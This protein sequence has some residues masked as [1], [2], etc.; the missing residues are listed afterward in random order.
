MLTIALTSCNNDPF[1]AGWVRLAVTL[2][3]AKVERV[4][5]ETLFGRPR[6]FGS[7][8]DYEAIVVRF[9]S[10]TD[11]YDY[12]REA[13]KAIQVRCWVDGSS[14]GDSFG[15][16]G[17]GPFEHGIDIS[18]LRRRNA[19]EA[20]LAPR[21]DGRHG[22]TAYVFINLTADSREYK[23][24]SPAMHLDLRTDSWS[25]IGCHV[26]GVEMVP[27]PFPR[28]NDLVISNERFHELL[29]TVSPM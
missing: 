16:F 17:V 2:E 12:F 5:Y 27:L 24:G 14:A 15:G 4:P 8:A 3:D 20:V 19:D 13:G 21:S 26:I 9:S 11:L 1:R 18:R 29:A 7:S 22:Y 6:S 10:P 23:N 28:S 25:R